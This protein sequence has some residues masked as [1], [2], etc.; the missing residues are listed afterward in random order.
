MGYI[1]INAVFIAVFSILFV[2]T[3]LLSVDKSYLQL[4]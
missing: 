1:P 2:E 4:S 3:Y